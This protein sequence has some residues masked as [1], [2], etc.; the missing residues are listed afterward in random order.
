MTMTE[1]SIV[2]LIGRLFPILFMLMLVHIVNVLFRKKRIEPETPEGRDAAAGTAETTP[3]GDQSNDL[4][5]E[6][7]QMRR[8]P[9]VERQ[10][11]AY[12]DNV[13]HETKAHGSGDIYENRTACQAS[14]KGSSIY[15]GRQRCSGETAPSEYREARPVP[16]PDGSPGQKP[17]KDVRLTAKEMRAAIIATEVLGKPKALRRR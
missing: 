3:A 9:R 11:G 10:G 5:F 17:G 1:S 13:Y 8:A 12:Q 7:P 15:E 6:I 16:A 14:E 2:K 4:G